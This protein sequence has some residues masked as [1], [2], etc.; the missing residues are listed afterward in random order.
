MDDTI[1]LAYLAGFVDGEGNV[2]IAEAASNGLPSYPRL[3]VGQTNPEPLIMLEDRFG[4]NVHSREIK[5]ERKPMFVWVVQNRRAYEALKNLLPYLTVKR[6]QAK[7][8][9]EFYEFVQLRKLPSYNDRA[10]YVDAIRTEN[11]REHNLERV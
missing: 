5:L 10:A 6:E 7:L 11:R 9:I 8:A 1:L 4:G 2:M 3:T